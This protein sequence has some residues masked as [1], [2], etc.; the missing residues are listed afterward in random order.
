MD[1]DTLIL[2]GLLFASLLWRITIYINEQRKLF[3][4]LDKNTKDKLKRAERVR[5]ISNKL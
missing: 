3:E 5:K 1:I 4:E 2:M